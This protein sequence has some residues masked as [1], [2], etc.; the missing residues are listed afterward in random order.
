MGGPLPNPYTD[1]SSLCLTDAHAGFG[2]VYD[3][4]MCDL[5]SG[6]VLLGFFPRS[7]MPFLVWLVICFAMGLIADWLI[8]ATARKEYR[9][10]MRLLS[11]AFS[12]GIC[13]AGAYLMA[14]F[15][16]YVYFEALLGRR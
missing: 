6:N 16:F 9:H 2:A 5:N 12:V 7:L 4:A 10:S 13:L 11:L 1:K 14:V 8:R 3:N 15:P